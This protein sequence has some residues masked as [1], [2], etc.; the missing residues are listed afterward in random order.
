VKCIF[1]LIL[2]LIIF[3]HTKYTIW[4]NCVDMCVRHGR[5]SIE[6]CLSEKG[7]LAKKIWETLIHGVDKWSRVGMGVTQWPGGQW[8]TAGVIQNYC[9][10]GKECKRCFSTNQTKLRGLIKSQ[11]LYN[12]LKVHSI[13]L[14]FLIKSSIMMTLWKLFCLLRYKQYCSACVAVRQLLGW[15]YSSRLWSRMV[16]NCCKPE[17]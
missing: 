2:V 12:S 14:F 8:K 3:K 9:K 6:I 1:A 15:W 13:R 17:W 16:N 7:A 11:L 5:G 10:P 4:K